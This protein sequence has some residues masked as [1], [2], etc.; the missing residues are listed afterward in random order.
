MNM[1]P[2]NQRAI[3][4]IETNDKLNRIHDTT[5][6]NAM[7]RDEAVEFIKNHP[8]DLIAVVQLEYNGAV[9]TAL[10]HDPK[11]PAI[12]WHRLV[13]AFKAD[14]MSVMN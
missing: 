3:E 13:S 12:W 14:G 8:S 7:N 11:T 5:L 6:E 10:Y 2:Q 1:L 4:Y 9:Y